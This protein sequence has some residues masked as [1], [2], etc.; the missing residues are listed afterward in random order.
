MKT[1]FLLYFLAILMLSLQF[2]ACISAYY[3][4]AV[5]VPGVKNK[6][7][8]ELNV[9]GGTSGIE[10]QGAY[11]FNKHLLLMGDMKYRQAGNVF[12][13]SEVDESLF[14]YP[15]IL[16]EG[17]PGYVNR[18]G[19]YGHFSLIGGMG[20]SYYNRWVWQFDRGIN[21]FSG[22][23]LKYFVQP[24]LG[25]HSDFGLAVASLRYVHL[26]IEENN[27]LFELDLLEP[28][29]TISYGVPY[30]H[31]HLQAGYSFPIVEND[32]YY[33]KVFP[34]FFNTGF[35]YKFIKEEP[36]KGEKEVF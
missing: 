22:N 5:Y 15:R 30:L 32:A 4:S 34:F 31:F 16:I 1:K 26:K 21:E 13:L 6:N 2:Y 19:D 8:G 28:A 10:L 35:S 3:P 29:M 12:H 11:A 18:F 24:S 33:Y 7:E 14:A 25:L 27:S 23:Y 9:F 17:G 20:M 36:Q